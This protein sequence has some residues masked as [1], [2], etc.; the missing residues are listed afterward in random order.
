MSKKGAVIRTA[1][2]NGI[3]TVEGWDGESRL[4]LIRIDPAEY[5]AGVRDG[6]TLNGFKQ[7]L[8]E[9]WQAERFGDLEIQW[10]GDTALA[11]DGFTIDDYEG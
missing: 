6:A 5:P 7:G 11:A 8:V 4:G 2:A 10:V 1:I 3:L 9:L